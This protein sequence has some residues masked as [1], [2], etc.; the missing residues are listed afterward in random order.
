MMRF[1]GGDQIS[2]DHRE[3]MS[4]HRR[5]S[6]TGD[7]IQPP[8]PLRESLA[9]F[10]S[11]AAAGLVADGML[12][13]IDT[14]RTRLWVMQGGPSSAMYPYRYRGVTHGLASVL[15][16]EGAT[17]L[18]KGFG[19]VA[20]LTPLANGLYFATYEYAKKVL[21][22]DAQGARYLNISPPY[23]PVIAASLG[24]AFAGLLWTPMDVVKQH[25]QASVKR[26][27]SGVC[28]GLVAVHRRGGVRGGL[29]KGYWS[30]LALEAPF[31]A[32][33]FAVYEWWK[34]KCR[35]YEAA[36]KTG[37]RGSVDMQS[38]RGGRR[39]PT[40]LGDLTDSGAPSGGG[41]RRGLNEGVQLNAVH[42][43]SGGFVSG[44]IAAIVT[45]PVD[46]VKTRIQ[47]RPDCMGIMHTIV[48]VFSNEGVRAFFRGGIARMLT[49]APGCALT[50]AVFEDGMVWLT[51]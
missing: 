13:P 47:V 14:V 4:M 27:Y 19:A 9:Q 50:V 11:G 6:V 42:H 21:E 22:R 43:I 10:T 40:N 51:D 16:D 18:F 28:M 7:R 48:H 33:H 45:A 8:S 17:A 23:W 35:D 24:T 3:V 29:L 34:V 46:L 26:V 25:Q 49:Q 15:R 32:I 1:S 39:T 5:V 44:A 2:R 36:M 30:F 38:E 12:H 31:A 20:L 41:Q 37:A